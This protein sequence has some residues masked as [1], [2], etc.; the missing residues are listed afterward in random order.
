M[1]LET[2][3]THDRACAA[4]IQPNSASFR[5]KAA[6]RRSASE[7]CTEKPIITPTRLPIA[8]QGVQRT[9][10]ATGQSRLRTLSKGSFLAQ[11]CRLAAVHKVVSYLRKG[12]RAA[13]ATSIVHPLL[14][15][16]SGRPNS[17]K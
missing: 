14:P 2:S 16:L 3:G 10:S 5:S 11:G 6:T 9:M 13:G 8:A 4:K 17:D 1:P 12:G 15:P 7:F